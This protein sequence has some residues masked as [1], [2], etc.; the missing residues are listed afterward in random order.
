MHTWEDHGEVISYDHDLY[1]DGPELQENEDAFKRHLL[2]EFLDYL[3]VLEY[4]RGY[5][6]HYYTV[7]IWKKYGK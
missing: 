5:D 4:S 6:G 7:W 1:I 2:L 3:K